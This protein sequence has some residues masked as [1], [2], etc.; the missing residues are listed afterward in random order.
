MIFVV[1]SYKIDLDSKLYDLTIECLKSIRQQTNDKIILID[2]SSNFDDKFKDLLK[3]LNI[4]L[5]WVEFSNLSKSWNLACR[6]VFY[7]FE[8]GGIRPADI[9]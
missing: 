4:T 1:T 2:D 9:L 7:E 3:N 5:I 8:D 6:K